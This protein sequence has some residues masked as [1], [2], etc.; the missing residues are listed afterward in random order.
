M[1]RTKKKLCFHPLFSQLLV[2]FSR[3]KFGQDSNRRHKPT[4]ASF[5]L[6]FIQFGIYLHFFRPTLCQKNTNDQKCIKIT[7]P[8]RWLLV[9]ADL[10]EFP[11]DNV[12]T[13]HLDESRL[14]M[15]NIPT[16][17]N[18]FLNQGYF[19]L[20]MRVTRNRRQNLGFG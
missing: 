16:P 13:G 14:K 6:R 4:I 7:R 19:I 8:A 1:Y 18:Q 5:F 11:P 20:R 9:F 12:N 3:R 10:T 17:L 15:Y 2:T